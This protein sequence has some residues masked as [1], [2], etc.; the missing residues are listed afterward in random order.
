VPNHTFS[1]RRNQASILR[2]Q[3]Y[4]QPQYLTVSPKSCEIVI[5]QSCISI[6]N[7]QMSCNK[8]RNNRYR[9]NIRQR[10]RNI[11]RRYK[12]KDAKFPRNF[13]L[14]SN[15]GQ[16]IRHNWKNGQRTILIK[17]PQMKCS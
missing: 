14:M 15:R 3:K 4:R 6:F 13:I 11:I 12:Q 9:N 7:L 10:I 17:Y 8:N 5:H 16:T 2:L 1:R